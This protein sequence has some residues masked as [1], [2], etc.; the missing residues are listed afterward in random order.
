MKCHIYTQVNN[1]QE[2]TAN[3]GTLNESLLHTDNNNDMTNTRSEPSTPAPGWST[4]RIARLIEPWKRSFSQS[5][6]HI[7]KARGLYM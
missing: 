5:A 4:E 2:N 7:P 3:E 1:I 6:D